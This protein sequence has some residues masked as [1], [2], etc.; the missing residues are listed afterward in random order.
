MFFRYFK[1]CTFLL[2][3]QSLSLS[4]LIATGQENESHEQLAGA[5]IYDY[6]PTTKLGDHVFGTIVA[7]FS[8]PV[9]GEYRCSHGGPV[10]LEYADGT[11][12][13]F[14]ANTSS[15]NVDGWSEY[16]LSKD[17]GK[18][19]DMYHPFPFSLEAYKKDPKRPVWIEEG[20][21]TDKGT[22]ILLLS[23]IEEGV[24][25][26]NYIMRSHDHGKSWSD[27]QPYAD[28]L[29]GYPAAVATI[30]S[31]NYVLFD[32]PTD[33]HELHVSTDDGQTWQKRS[34]LP[35]QKEAWYGSLCVMED[36]RLL[37]GAYD[38]ID[39]NGSVDEHYFYYCISQ[40]N[41]HT[42]SEPQKAYLDKK[43]RDPELAYLDGNYYLH[44][45]SGHSGE[46]GRRF[47]LY[48]SDDGIDWKPG[49]II[50]GDEGHPDGYSHNCIINKYDEQTPNELMVL[51]SI[52]YEPPRTSE[53]VFF[54]KSDDRLSD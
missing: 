8:E 34:T 10:C 4:S 21:V 53:Y 24:R 17:S 12:A 46:G 40:D 23:Q 45:R 22:A 31:T 7:D 6:D 11:L 2:V 32:G 20:L 9:D 14:Y 44:G 5:V 13:T 42:W 19:W 38:S 26:Q 50:S 27:A 43:I 35:L 25:T 37:A 30:E 16:A 18:T 33:F 47:V 3:A 51:Y 1:A 15:H 52:T 54:L 29:I 41:G 36:G 28:K 49:I 48:Q 39:E